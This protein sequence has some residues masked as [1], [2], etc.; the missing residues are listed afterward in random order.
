[1]KPLKLL[2]TL[3]IA[4]ACSNVFAQTFACKDW[5]LWEVG[6]GG[7]EKK[8]TMFVGEKK[9]DILVIKNEDKV[10]HTLILLGKWSA[11]EYYANKIRFERKK[12]IIDIYGV[13]SNARNNNY[14]YDFVIAR[15]FPLGVVS[16]TFCNYQ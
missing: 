13:L 16:H 14:D 5:R 15:H 9:G 3:I 1:M 11:N 4:L 12:E 8:G 2:T 6:H 10:E 7:Q